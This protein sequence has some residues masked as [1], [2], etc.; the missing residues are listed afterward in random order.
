VMTT[1]CKP[2]LVRRG[3]GRGVLDEFVCPS[4]K[5]LHVRAGFMAAIVLAPGQFSLEQ[6]C[7]GKLPTSPAVTFE[8]TVQVTLGTFF[9]TRPMTSR[10][11]SSAIS[12]RCCFHHISALALNYHRLAVNSKACDLPRT[13]ALMF[14]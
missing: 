5:I 1:N 13:I 11:K 2:S 7:A 3:S 4:D 10:S 6:P 14:A 8:I 9:G 12:G